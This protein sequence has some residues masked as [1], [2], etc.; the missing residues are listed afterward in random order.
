MTVGRQTLRKQ[1]GS[2]PRKKP[3]AD[4]FQQKLQHES[5]GR[6]ERVYIAFAIMLSNFRNQHFAAAAAN[7][8]GNFPVVEDVLAST[9]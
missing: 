8:G 3:G 7:L 4:S 5:V 2:G 1:L 9:N 6:K